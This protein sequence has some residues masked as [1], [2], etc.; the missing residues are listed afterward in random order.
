[1]L[2]T[3]SA[4]RVGLNGGA[5]RDSTFLHCR[6]ETAMSSRSSIETF[7]V[8]GD[9]EHCV[10]EIVPEGGR[11]AEDTDAT[12]WGEFLRDLEENGM[13]ATIFGHKFHR[14]EGAMTSSDADHFL[15]ECTLTDS[16]HWVWRPR[17][18]DVKDANLSNIANVFP[19]EQLMSSRKV[20]HAV[21]SKFNFII[22]SL[23]VLKV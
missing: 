19:I 11:I 14:P 23:S 15:I 7:C 16:T 2:L 13:D 18:V 20:P 22:F 17:K 1:M 10:L 6:S 5:H 3:V 8:S 21:R 9:S 4:G 12:S